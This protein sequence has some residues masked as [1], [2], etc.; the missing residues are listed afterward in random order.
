ML[1]RKMAA[2]RAG[3]HDRNVVLLGGFEERLPSLVLKDS[4]PRDQQRSLRTPDHLQ[5]LLDLLGRWTGARLGAVFIFAIVV[6][7]FR[8]IG[9]S[10]SG[11][12]AREIE[13]HWAG[14]ARFQ[15]AKR[16]PA[17]LPDAIRSDQPLAVLLQT[18]GQRLLIARLDERLAIVAGNLHVAGQDQQRCAGSVCR[19]DIH[20]H[21]RQAGT[22][23]AGTGRDF[24]GGTRESVSCRA[25][26]TFAAPAVGWDAGRGDG[27]DHGIV[28]RT[29]KQCRQLFFLAE[30][31]EH[32]GAGHALPFEGPRLRLF[33]D[34]I[35]NLFR[36][37]DRGNAR[38]TRRLRVGSETRDHR[39]GAH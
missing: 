26:R 5:R 16:V 14:D 19:G 1:V 31:G 17:V 38:R 20:D 36:N 12:F 37:G 23:G 7:E 33:V 24:A 34:R 8:G 15:I 6:L 35:D 30:L 39:A 13:M 4:L 25:H 28:A 10:G 27:V 9:E 22:L 11:H 2:R 32:L 18:R 3:G 29:A 21:V